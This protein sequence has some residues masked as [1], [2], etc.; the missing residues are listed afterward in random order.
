MCARMPKMR[1]VR[2]PLRDRRRTSRPG[3]SE[4]VGDVVTTMGEIADR[5][6][7]IADILG[8][9]DGIALQTNILA[10]NAAVEVARAGMQGRGFAVVASD[11]RSLVQRSAAAAQEIKAVIDS[12]TAT[13]DAGGRR[14]LVAPEPR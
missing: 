3:G 12:S 5:S 7:Q 1:G 14:L 10:L 9:I 2:R 6:R 8:V 13:V 4:V 11:V